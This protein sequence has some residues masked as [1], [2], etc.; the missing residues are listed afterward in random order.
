MTQKT[1]G[2]GRNRGKSREKGES[3]MVGVGR[4]GWTWM[5]KKIMDYLI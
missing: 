1:L 2:G 4:T 5:G 3:E